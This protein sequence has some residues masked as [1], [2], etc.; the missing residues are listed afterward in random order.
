MTDTTNNNAPQGQTTTTNGHIQDKLVKDS[1]AH[2]QNISAQA[3]ARQSKL[4]QANISDAANSD[5]DFT[6]VQDLP[7]GA[8]QGQQTTMPNNNVRITIQ[9]MIASTRTLLKQT[10]RPS[11]KRFLISV[12]TSIT[13][14]PL[15]LMAMKRRISAIKP[16]TK[17]KNKHAWLMYLHPSPKNTT[18]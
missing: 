8:P 12:M 3:Q 14:I 4:P 1:I 10:P 13:R 17:L 16:S 9:V 6:K 11:N 5:N 2:A 15:I 18:S 7:T